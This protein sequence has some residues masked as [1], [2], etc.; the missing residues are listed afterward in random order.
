MESKYLEIDSLKNIHAFV[1]L[2]KSKP[3][4]LVLGLKEQV[5]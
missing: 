3:Y 4:L 5:F 2:G 1:P